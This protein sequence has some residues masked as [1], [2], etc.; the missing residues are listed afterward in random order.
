[1]KEGA[2]LQ[3]ANLQ[4]TFYSGGLFTRKSNCESFVAVNSISFALQ[5]GEILGL[6]GPNGAGKTTTVQMLLGTLTPTAGSIAYFGRDFFTHRSEILKHV[7]F[8]SAY[9]RLP[10]RLTVYENLD[11]YARLY[12]IARSDRAHAIKTFLQAFDAWDLRDKQ[13]SDLSAGQ[14]TRILI[15]KAFLPKPKVLL[16]DEPTASL[17]PDI[18]HEVRHFILTQQ[19]EYNVSVL[20]TSHNM[21]EVSELCD[22]VLV[23]RKGTIIADDTP[24]RLAASVA[25]VR[26]KLI[27]LDGMKRTVAHAQTQ[28]MKYVVQDRVVAIETDESAIASLL[29]SL[30][31]LGIV[32]SHISIEKPTL[33]DY[34]LH[35]AKQ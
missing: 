24:E 17:D 11:V 28:G 25:S 29:S 12:G 3:V 13:V 33:E 21:D 1:M 23:L 16:L 8:A 9:T 10:T 15:V 6:L 7:G 31:H 22:R 34:F 4:K 18:A 27:I 20:F 26:V 32:Y 2:V 19:H 35:I 14:L 5:Q 30:A